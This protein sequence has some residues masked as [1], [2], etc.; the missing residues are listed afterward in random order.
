[1]PQ[2]GETTLRSQRSLSELRLG[3]FFDLLYVLIIKDLKVRYKNSFFGYLWSLLNPLCFALIFYF[4][5]KVIV[6]FPVENYVAYLLT[7]LFPWQWISNSL[8]TSTT[9]L[10]ANVNLIKKVKCP[11][12][13]FPLS[14]VIQDGIHFL[15]SLPVI[16]M[17]L[18]LYSINV[19]IIQFFYIIVLIMIQTTMIYGISLLLS[20]INLFFR[21]LERLVSLALTFIFYLTPIIYTVD[22]IPESY[23]WIFYCNPFF[24]LIELWHLIFLKG[25]LSYEYLLYSAVYTTLFFLFGQII[26]NKLSAKFAE[27]L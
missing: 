23:R 13:V 14:I 1:M 8:M 25:I 20:S 9:V 19:S 5:F 12:Y 11:S 15:L 16:F 22:F 17:I 3:Y 2:Q 4:V 26:F 27:A 7:G 24:P 10:L 18:F 6:R 21:D